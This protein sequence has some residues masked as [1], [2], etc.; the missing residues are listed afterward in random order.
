MSHIDPALAKEFTNLSQP[1]IS[2]D[3]VASGGRLIITKCLGLEVS[4]LRPEKIR[5]SELVLLREERSRSLVDGY[6]ELLRRG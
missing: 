2:F 4:E 3:H 6:I 1:L 5:W